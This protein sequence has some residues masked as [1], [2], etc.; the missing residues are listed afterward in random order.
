M[1][2][3]IVEVFKNI[4]VF[5]KG[6]IESNSDIIKDIWTLTNHRDKQIAWIML[7]IVLI[8]LVFG[9]QIAIA[10]AIIAGLYVFL[11]WAYSDGKFD[12]PM[13]ITML[14]S[15]ILIVWVADKILFVSINMVIVWITIQFVVIAGRGI[16]ENIS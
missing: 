15:M 14:V 6:L 7:A 10:A 5:L 16:F 2:N 1:R 12:F 4:Y 13:V 8:S 11:H 9:I 3:D